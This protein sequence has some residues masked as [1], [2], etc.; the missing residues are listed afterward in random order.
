MTTPTA[1][2]RLV[3]AVDELTTDRRRSVYLE[4]YDPKQH[5]WVRRKVDCG[6]WSLIGLLQLDVQRDDDT[7]VK[8]ESATSRSG[9]TS[10]PPG[11]YAPREML[12]GLTT[13]LDGWL[14][15]LRIPPS[16]YPAYNCGLLR[17]IAPKLEEQPIELNWLADDLAH[18]AE[19]LRGYAGLELT[20]QPRGACPECAAVGRLTIW[21]STEKRR[22][23]RGYCGHCH[24]NWDQL[25]VD[26][27]IYHVRHAQPLEDVNTQGMLGA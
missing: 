16:P 19:Q 8:L 14:V 9:F 3:D 6:R 10:R 27:L 17:D 26:Q 4:W 25:T 20:H 18:W 24:H 1:Y 5:R 2:E 7:A 23:T 15:W 22:P 21:V 13:S 12:A 11:H